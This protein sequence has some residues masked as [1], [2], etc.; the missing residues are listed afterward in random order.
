MLKNSSVSR[1]LEAT[2]TLYIHLVKIILNS[3]VLY[4]TS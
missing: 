4:H 1:N 2:L 3:P